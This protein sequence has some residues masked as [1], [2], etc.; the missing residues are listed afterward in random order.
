MYFCIGLLFIFDYYFVLYRCLIPLKYLPAFHA[1]R[2]LTL[3]SFW[4]PVRYTDCSV[5]KWTFSQLPMWL[6]YGWILV[7]KYWYLNL[8]ISIWMS[9]I[10]ILCIVCVCVGIHLYTYTHICMH[11]CVYVHMESDIYDVCSDWLSI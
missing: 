11:V 2:L 10:F 3:C 8:N 7:F 6:I 5:E 9:C 1:H 4:P